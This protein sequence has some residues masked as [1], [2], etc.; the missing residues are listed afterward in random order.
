MRMLWPLIPLVAALGSCSSPPK[1]P[2]VNES[3]KRPVNS[4]IAV[5]LQTCKTALRNSMKDSETRLPSAGMPQMM[6]SYNWPRFPSWRF[7]VPLAR[8]SASIASATETER[9]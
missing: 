8:S 6:R 9:Q 7:S 1:P 2:T 3:A 5:E 4:A